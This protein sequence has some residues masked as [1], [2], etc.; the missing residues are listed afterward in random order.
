MYVSDIRSGEIVDK[1]TILGDLIKRTKV[2]ITKDVAANYLK[3]IGKP[4]TNAEV[5]KIADALLNNNETY[6]KK[7]ELILAIT[8]AFDKNGDVQVQ[9][10]FAIY[11]DIFK[12]ISD[13]IPRIF[14][15]SSEEEHGM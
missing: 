1:D 2:R 6:Y 11:K 10:T 4:A 9:N 15:I 8:K 13:L 14:F 7:D 12:E 5:N 3:A